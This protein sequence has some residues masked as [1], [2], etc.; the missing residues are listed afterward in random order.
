MKRGTDGCLKGTPG[1]GARTS[2]SN[3]I[4]TVTCSNSIA[5]PD[6]FD[7]EIQTYSPAPTGAPS[8]PTISPAPT[9]LSVNL[10]LGIYFDQVPETISWAIRSK[11]GKVVY[12]E[13]RPGTYRRPI[14]HIFEEIFVPPGEEYEFIIQ[15]ERGD[16]IL[17]GG[18]VYDLYLKDENL[19][20]KLFEGEGQ[21]KKDQKETFYVPN[22]DEVPTPAPTG[23]PAPTAYTQSLFLTIFFDAW[24][25]DISWMIVDAEAED[26]V[27]AE[28]LTGEYRYGTKITEELALPPDKDYIFIM[29][30]SFGDGL[31]SPGYGIWMQDENGE[32]LYLFRGDGSFGSERRH[33]FYFEPLDIVFPET[34]ATDV[35]DEI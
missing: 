30:D 11:Q 6:Y 18:I 31:A 9:A 20:M 34:N 15:D 16:G 1:V 10:E 24:H 2:S 14:D 5:P 4:R 21:F 26:T 19:S 35:E 28:K 32:K 3:W 12:K 33:E 22:L 13:V 25:Q 8:P 23:S 27:Y 7:C 17:G 29:Q